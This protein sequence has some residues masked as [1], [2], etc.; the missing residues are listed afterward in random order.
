MV[1]CDFEKY[2]EAFSLISFN[3]K[4]GSR[5]TDLTTKYTDVGKTN[6]ETG[7]PIQPEYGNRPQDPQ[8]VP[9]WWVENPAQNGLLR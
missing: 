2:R 5:S 4:L 8:W 1:K 6:N 3:E 7:N 9:D